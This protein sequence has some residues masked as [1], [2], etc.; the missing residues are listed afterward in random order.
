MPPFK[1]FPTDCPSAAIPIPIDVKSHCLPASD[2]ERDLRSINGNACATNFGS[3]Y[4][5]EGRA[6]YSLYRY[7]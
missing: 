4:Q 5:I 7:V 2:S 3:C 6:Y 1:E